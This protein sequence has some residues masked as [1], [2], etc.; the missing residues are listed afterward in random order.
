MYAGPDNKNRNRFLV[1]NIILMVVI[2]LIARYVLGFLM[3]YNYDVHSWALIMENIE[4]GNGLYGLAG[5]NYAP[6]WGYILGSISVVAG[7]VGVDVYGMIP[8][9]ALPLL[10]YTDWFFTSYITSIEFNMLVKTIL[11]MFDLIAGYMIWWIV[12]DRTGD[13]R[14][15]EIA[16]GLWFLCPFVIAVSSVGGMFDSLSASLTMMCIVFVIRDRNL[17]AGIVLGIAALM[18]LFPAFLIFILIAYIFTKE[19]NKVVAVKKTI[20]SAAGVMTSAGVLLLPQII[21]GDLSSCF[22]FLTSRATDNIGSGLGDIERYGTV[23]AYVVILIVSILLGIHFH[24]KE[25]KNPDSRILI[26]ILLNLTVVFLFP[27]TPQYML[28]LAPFLIMQIVLVDEHFK[29]PY[30]VLA[31]GTTM[32]ALACNAVNLMSLAEFSGII[33]VDTVLWAI[34]WFQTPFIGISGMRI[35][36]YGGAIIQ[37]I[38]TLSILPIFYREARDNHTRALSTMNE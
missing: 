16:F 22:A 38:G 37:Y 5:Y 14:K 28:L 13:R 18:K 26:Y 32:F 33:S 35:L 10:D 23:T 3:T 27:S 7:F 36:Y 12:S 11:F 2:G 30:M 6:P 17:L 20:L 15:A 24:K 1:R 21:T 9:E 34:E 25:K 29:I 8:T 4:S 19:T 31:I